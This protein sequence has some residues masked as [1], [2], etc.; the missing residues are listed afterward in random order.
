MA[1]SVSALDGFGNP[2]DW[3]AVVKLPQDAIDCD[4]PPPPSCPSDAS[5]SRDASGGGQYWDDKRAS[6]LCYLYA[7]NNKPEFTWFRDAGFGCLSEEN[8]PVTQTLNQRPGNDYA[9]WNDQMS[10]SAIPGTYKDCSSPRAHSKGA[11]IVGKSGRGVILNASTP[12]FPDPDS[13]VLGCSEDDNTEVTQHFFAASLPIDAMYKWKKAM[14]NAELCQVNDVDDGGVD[15]NP[16]IDASKT[17]TSVEVQTT[18]GEPL[19]IIVKGAKQDGVPWDLVATE[20]NADLDVLSWYANPE[21]YPVCK[22]QL[23]PCLTG[24]QTDWQESGSIDKIASHSINVVTSLDFGK[25]CEADISTCG[26]EKQFCCGLGGSAKYK[27]HAKMAAATVSDE[28]E[29]DDNSVVVFGSMNMQGNPDTTTPCSS[30]QMGRGGDF[31]T[32]KNK[33]LHE[34]MQDLF[35]KTCSCQDPWQGDGYSTSGG[36]PSCDCCATK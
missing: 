11:M 32:L 15:L 31:Y 20:T 33:D 4:C 9:I 29:N 5:D 19:T 1:A 26:T 7:D 34:S 8:N 12:D 36:G 25:Y 22:N 14:V 21:Y 24:W 30:S 10:K 23:T 6:G 3:F 35:Y 18:N 17:N 16:D 27:N 28:S 2:V 13:N